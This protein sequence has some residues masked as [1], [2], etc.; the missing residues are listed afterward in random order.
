MLLPR[1]LAVRDLRGHEQTGLRY[2]ASH[3]L[4]SAKNYLM[5]RKSSY[6]RT[7]KGHRATV[8]MSTCYEGIYAAVN[9][10]EFM[11]AR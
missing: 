6:S 7:G 11:W 4:L 5:R 3:R 9:A 1:H 8:S 10:G 2:R